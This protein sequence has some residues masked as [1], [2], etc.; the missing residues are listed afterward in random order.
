MEPNIF[1]FLGGGAFA[2]IVI[3]EVLMFLKSKPNG[4]ANAET[5]SV[6]REIKDSNYRN[7]DKLEAINRNLLVMLE[8]QSNM[9]KQVDAIRN[10]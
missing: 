8:R 9:E 5:I 2:Y 6:L 1:Q 7:G 4:Q 3:K 10:R